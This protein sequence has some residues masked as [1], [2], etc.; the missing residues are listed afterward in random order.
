M[1]VRRAEESGVKASGWDFFNCW[2]PAMLDCFVLFCVVC[3]LSGVVGCCCQL[4]DWR[5]PETGRQKL[6]ESC[7]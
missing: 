2:H 4:I 3:L 1:G 6:V 5:R 7:E